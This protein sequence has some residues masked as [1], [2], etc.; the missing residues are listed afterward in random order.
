MVNRRGELLA[1]AIGLALLTQLA[2]C[3]GAPGTGGS[4]SGTATKTTVD[5][6]QQIQWGTFKHEYAKPGADLRRYSRVQLAK[7]DI[8]YTHGDEPKTLRSQDILRLQKIF[9][10]DVTRA[11]EQGNGIEVATAPGPNVLL[12][13]PSVLDLKLVPPREPDGDASNYGISNTQCIIIAT[14]RDSVTRE[15]LFRVAETEMPAWDPNTLERADAGNFWS[16]LQ[17]EFRNWGNRLR[18]LLQNP[19]TPSS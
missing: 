1:L 4:A 10:E 3:A 12:I 19:P 9:R 7:L 14:L 6:L 16:D 13:E 11:L 8:S 2:A 5:G 17:L 15:I 18:R